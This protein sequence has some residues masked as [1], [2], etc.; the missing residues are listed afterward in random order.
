MPGAEARQGSGGRAS[1]GALGPT[2][3]SY[4][5]LRVCL[6]GD[7]SMHF[8]DPL[9]DLATSNLSCLHN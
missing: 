1:V 8:P 3:D 9:V 6:C 5:V 7:I 4:P 2:P